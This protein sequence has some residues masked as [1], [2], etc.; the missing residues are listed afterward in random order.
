[1]ISGAARHPR[2]RTVRAVQ[3]KRKEGRMIRQ[4]IHRR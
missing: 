1:M 4:T 2:Q 3:T